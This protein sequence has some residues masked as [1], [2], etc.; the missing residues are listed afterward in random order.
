MS[1]SL[2]LKQGEESYSQVARNTTWMPIPQCCLP[3]PLV[4]REKALITGLGVSLFN[5]L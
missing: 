2:S 4:Y 3:R 1:G 5:N